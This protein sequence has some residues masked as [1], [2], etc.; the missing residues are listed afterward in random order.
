M[1]QS[2]K[3]ICSRYLAY[4]QPCQSKV[5]T[6]VEISIKKSGYADYNYRLNKQI[7]ISNISALI[8]KF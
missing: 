4:Q 3:Q 6:F 5:S 8:L 7:I 2:L 1:G